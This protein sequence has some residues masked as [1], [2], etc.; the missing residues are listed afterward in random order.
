WPTSRCS[1]NRAPSTSSRGRERRG[2][3]PATS[4]RTFRPGAGGGPPAPA[5]GRSWA[6]AADLDVPVGFHVIVRD[7]PG[8]RPR[9][10]AGT[11]GASLFNFAFLAIDVMAAFTEMLASGV[12]EKHP[13]LRCTVLESGA[14]WIAAWLDRMDHKYEVMR[15]IT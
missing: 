13:N 1:T 4:P 8:A 15:S 2:A 11:P 6:P 9:M 14:T 5:S 12:F 3:G 10:V 7:T